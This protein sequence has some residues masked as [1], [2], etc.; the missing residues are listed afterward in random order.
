MSGATPRLSRN[1]ARWTS[2]LAG[3]LLAAGSAAARDELLPRKR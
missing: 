3:L 1:T 2:A